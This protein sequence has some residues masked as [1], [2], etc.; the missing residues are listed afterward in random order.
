MSSAASPGDLTTVS[1]KSG[2]ANP[3]P[4]VRIDDVISLLIPIDTGGWQRMMTWSS[5]DGRRAPFLAERILGY[6]VGD[7]K[8]TV[9]TFLSMLVRPVEGG[10]S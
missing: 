3:N 5:T 6:W 2:S 1:R 8:K 9:P 7:E 10:D 4:V